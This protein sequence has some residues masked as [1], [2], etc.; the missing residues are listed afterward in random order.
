[1]KFKNT[2]ILIC[3]AQLIQLPGETLFSQNA[4]AKPTRESSEE[5]FSRGDYEKAYLQYRELLLMYNKDPLYKY[6]SGVC[7]VKL[8]REPAEAASLLLQAIQTAG[9][10]KPLPPDGLFYLARAQQMSGKYD[11]AIK[12]FNDYSEQV[13]KKTS[14][15][16]GVAG[17]L[18]QC[19]N[20][21]GQITGSV[22]FICSN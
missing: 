4:A 10:V 2:I 16:M 20:R 1:M 13:G 9:S 7:L 18:E 3:L 14:Q 19:R 12:T 17:F 15:E 21:K 22:Q 6:Y 11:E 8:N 5:A